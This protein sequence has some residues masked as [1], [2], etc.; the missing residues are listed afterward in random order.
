M[1][2]VQ[3]ILG[4]LLVVAMLLPCVIL[5]IN[6]AGTGSIENLYDVKNA[7]FGAAPEYSYS[8]YTASNMFCSSKVISVREGNTITVGPVFASEDWFIRTYND[9]GEAV[10]RV[11]RNNCVEE[12]S[13]RD[14]AKIYTYTVPAGIKYVCVTNSYM[15]YDCTLVTKNRTFTAEEY[16]AHMEKQGINVDFLK[17]TTADAANAANLFSKGDGKETFLYP[18]KAED[19]TLHTGAVDRDRSREWTVGVG[20]GKLKEGDVIYAV[21]LLYEERSTPL[22]NIWFKEDYRYLTTNSALLYEDLGRGFGIYVVRVPKGATKVAVTL[23]A[24]NYDDG[25]SLMTVNQPFTG[26]SYR[27]LFNIDLEKDLCDESSPLNGLKGLFVGDSISNGSHDAK[28]YL[29]DPE[30][31]RGWAGGI[32]AATGMISTNASVSG[33]KISTGTKWIWNQQNEHKNEE[34]DVVVMQGGVNDAGNDGKLGKII[35]DVDLP[36]SELE[37]YKDTYLGGLQHLFATVRENWPDATFFF[38]ANYKLSGSKALSGQRPQLGTWFA[39]AKELCELYGV[40]FI[41]LYNNEE[42]KTALDIDSDSR[43]YIH[44][45]THPNAAGYDIIT[46]Y[47]QAE[48]ER[49]MAEIQA[50]D[51]TTGDKTESGSNAE[52]D[53]DITTKPDGGTTADPNEGPDPGSTPAEEKKGCGS[54]VTAS[55]GFAAIALLI[56]AAVTLRKKETAEE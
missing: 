45:G 37:Q 10:K 12:A 35:E 24:G 34:F 17:P 23:G 6:A 44:D 39:K 8:E 38:I 51:E 31:W 22:F 47:I 32:A 33:A 14:N 20:E 46:P 13:L 5:P 41:D 56:P 54:V 2:T 4:A 50:S 16:V 9:N 7:T 42:L 26:E 25:I 19:G 43:I 1:K 15:F 40:H 36:S 11:T 27:K 55:L 52:P 29:D 21:A 49:V 53:G 28:S 48:M 3:R 30:N 18:Y